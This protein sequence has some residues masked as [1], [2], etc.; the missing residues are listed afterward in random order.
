MCN[1]N[2]KVP[3]SSNPTKRW[4]PPECNNKTSIANFKQGIFTTYGFDLNSYNDLI[5]WLEKNSSKIARIECFILK[6]PLFDFPIEVYSYFSFVHHAQHGFVFYDSNGIQ[7]RHF[8]LQLQNSSWPPTSTQPFDLALPCEVV[9]PKTNKSKTVMNFNDKT[10]IFGS[11]LEEENVKSSDLILM[12]RYVYYRGLNLS[13]LQQSVSYNFFMESYRLW[14]DKYTNANNTKKNILPNYGQEIDT[15][16]G[17]IYMPTLE[18]G[19]KIPGS[20]GG[21]ADGSLFIFNT[22]TPSYGS[23]NEGCIMNYASIINGTKKGELANKFKD[24]ASWVFR[25]YQCYNTQEQHDTSYARAYTTLST[26]QLNISWVNTILGNDNAK[27]LFTDMNNNWSKISDW[28]DSDPNCILYSKIIDTL[29]TSK[30]NMFQNAEY[31]SNEPLDNYINSP[32]TPFITVGTNYNCETF[33]RHIISLT[34]N[35]DSFQGNGTKLLNNSNDGNINPNGIK[36]DQHFDFTFSGGSTQNKPN[37]DST[38]NTTQNLFRAYEGTWPVA[39]YDDNYNNGVLVS[40]FNSNPIY[41]KDRE[42]YSKQSMLFQYLY[43]GNN[44]SAA[45]IS[46]NPLLV[47]MTNFFSIP[48]LQG[49]IKNK[50]GK[51]GS[52]ILTVLR[53]LMYCIFLYVFLGQ[54]RVFLSGYRTRIQDNFTFTYK[55][56]ENFDCEPAIYAFSIGSLNRSAIANTKLIT[57]LF[58]WLTNDESG[59]SVFDINNIFK[60]DPNIQKLQTYIQKAASTYKNSQKDFTNMNPN[61]VCSET[62]NNFLEKD[63]CIAASKIGGI[64]NFEE[65]WR[66]QQKAVASQELI[67]AFDFLMKNPLAITKELV[68]TLVQTAEKSVSFLALFLES[69][70][71]KFTTWCHQNYTS[72]PEIILQR[73]KNNSNN[74]SFMDYNRPKTGVCSNLST[75]PLLS[76]KSTKIEKYNTKWENKNFDVQ[77]NLRNPYKNKQYDIPVIVTSIIC[78]LIIVLVLYLLYKKNKNYK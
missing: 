9:D 59:K 26:S 1:I 7:L 64:S 10:A 23:L 22:F 11:F 58:R 52:H 28:D 74:S 44:I 30:S 49:L 60:N 17:N 32:I 19:Q 25:N 46:K 33:S 54:E 36:V 3:I 71:L 5:N 76:E 37:D 69:C 77:F 39:I 27:T 34:L 51:E 70:L 4:N 40:E 56:Y 29:N 47:A 45:E 15:S 21:D 53:M 50:T 73:Q 13:F 8:I 2:K 72:T 42:I 38:Y 48:F 55:P 75:C 43:N 78:L 6:H 63:S 68:Q 24:F 12:N 57:S 18:T 67:S 66:I 61:D 20:L 62:T 16:L 35:T 31:N 65:L 14:F 41:D